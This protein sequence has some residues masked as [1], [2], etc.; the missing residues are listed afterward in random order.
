MTGEQQLFDLEKDPGEFDDLGAKPEHAATLK[1]WR[2]RM[3]KHLS[4]RGPPFVVDGDL[5]LRPA[6]F[7]GRAAV[8]TW[9]YRVMVNSSI[10][11]LRSKQRRSR[12]ET[13]PQ[14]PPDPEEAAINTQMRERF[15]TALSEV[16]EQHRQVLVLR[17]L[18]GLTYPEIA[19]LLK[20]P[21]GTVKSALNRGRTRVLAV[22]DQRG[23]E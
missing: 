18:R 17:E 2:G 20:V 16:S 5:A 21:E 9:L 6:K 10:N 14:A 7:L 23:H 8:S 1:L 12:L 15:V 22:L 19:A 4:E 3:V 13:A 11:S